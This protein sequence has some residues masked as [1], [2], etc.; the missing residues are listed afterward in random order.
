[1]YKGVL[2]RRRFRKLRAVYRI[3]AFYHR[4][5]TAKF[6]RALLQTCQVGVLPHG[7]LANH[8]QG[9]QNMPDLGKSIK[10]PS[11][12]SLGLDEFIGYVQKVLQLCRCL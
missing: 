6:L 8:S 9:V 4:C 5:K 11:A 7:R 3:I 10:W 1:M 12:P 2:Q